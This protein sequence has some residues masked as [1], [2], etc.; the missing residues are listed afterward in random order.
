MARGKTLGQLIVALRH[1][2]RHS[3]D[4]ALGLNT[5]ASIKE[6]LARTQERL[7]DAYD[8]PFLTIYRDIPTI[9]GQRYYD[10]PTDL[11][12]EKLRQIEFRYANMWVPVRRGISAVQYNVCDSTQTAAIGSFTI[13]SG[14]AAAASGAFTVT[15]GSLGGPN[16]VTAITVNGVNLIGASVP[17]GTSHAATARDLT[18]AINAYAS[19]PKFTASVSNATVTIT[20]APDLGATAN[21]WPVVVTIG[22]TVTV[23]SVSAMAGGAD[24]QITAV[25]VSGT[26]ILPSPIGWRTSGSITAEAVV[27]AINA[28]NTVPKY[29]ATSLGNKVLV[30]AP[31]YE[32]S[33]ANARAIVVAT[34]GT[35]TTGTPTALAGGANGQR[36]DPVRAWKMIHT[37]VR[38]QLELWPVPA[39]A[40]TL[41][42]HG[43]LAL[44]ALVAEADVAI[45]DDRML[46]LFAAAEFVADKDK[47]R[48]QVLLGQADQIFRRL[49]SSL[50]DDSP[51]YLGGMPARN[52]DT[53][54]LRAIRG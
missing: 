44:P 26:D 28:G 39:S 18:S 50:S 24:N 21:S 47:S 9:P 27:I 14:T 54:S 49:R 48:A 6:V 53:Q 33:A 52:R 8:W 2:A 37:G 19:N 22:G 31:E 42:L 23:G 4:A 1:E 17:W 12:P 5:L 36:D 16:V 25:K 10:F 46:V 15:G 20:A 13:T 29:A 43:L 41:R 30:A 45:L 3:P 34:L 51:V 38:E 40:G 7:Y 35:V 32:G 11:N